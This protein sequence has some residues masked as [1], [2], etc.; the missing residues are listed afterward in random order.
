MRLGFVTE[1]WATALI[2][3]VREKRLCLQPLTTASQLDSGGFWAEHFFCN[4][5]KMS[6]IKYHL[7]WSAF[8]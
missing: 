2:P 7:A 6:Y 1:K 3:W 4:L 5:I 8:L